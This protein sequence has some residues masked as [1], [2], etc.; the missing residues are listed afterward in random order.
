MLRDV[1]KDYIVLC[2]NGETADFKHV[3]KVCPRIF[4]M[5]LEY[6]CIGQ[7]WRIY[8]LINKERKENTLKHA[9]AG[10]KLTD[11]QRATK[12]VLGFKVLFQF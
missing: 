1:I 9:R 3:S 8:T 11:G 12:H 6:I 10:I 4:M 2:F 7:Q 5:I